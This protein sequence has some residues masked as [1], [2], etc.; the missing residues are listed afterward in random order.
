MFKIA[1]TVK[2]CY[3]RPVYLWIDLIRKRP[4]GLDAG[5]PRQPKKNFSGFIAQP[6]MGD[7]IQLQELNKTDRPYPSAA[8][9]TSDNLLQ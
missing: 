1:A 2:H 7:C 6:M 3:I 8:L 4:I 5:R 9:G